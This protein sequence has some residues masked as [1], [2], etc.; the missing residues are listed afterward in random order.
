LKAYRIERVTR[1]DGGGEDA[2]GSEGEGGAV[3]G[4]NVHVVMSVLKRGVEEAMACSSVGRRGSVVVVVSN[5]NAPIQTLD[6]SQAATDLD[7]FKRHP[8]DPTRVPFPE[9]PE[10][11]AQ[12][13]IDLERLGRVDGVWRGGRGGEDGGREAEGEKVGIGGDVGDDGVELSGRVAAWK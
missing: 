6:P 13:R 12:L 3:E 10:A 2:V 7:P 5:I 1:V 11:H 4:S 9:P 8:F